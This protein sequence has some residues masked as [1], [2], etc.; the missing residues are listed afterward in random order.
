[1]TG[2]DWVLAATLTVL[3]AVQTALLVQGELHRRRDG[4]R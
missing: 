3:V 4:E 1:M 2:L